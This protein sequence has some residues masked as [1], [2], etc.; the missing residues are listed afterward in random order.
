MPENP[1]KLIC[2][3]VGTCEVAELSLMMKMWLTMPS[4]EEEATEFEKN[5]C[6]VL[7]VFENV[8]VQIF[9]VIG[10]CGVAKALGTVKM[11]P[12]IRCSTGNHEV[13]NH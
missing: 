11:W 3:V 10:T 13:G 8:Y 6:I 7:V 4:G 5:G 12:T 9:A 1:W 2:T